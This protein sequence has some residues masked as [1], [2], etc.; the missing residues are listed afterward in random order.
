[1][2][3][4]K[5]R[6]IN[7]TLDQ[8]QGALL[9]FDQKVQ[10]KNL[11]KHEVIEKYFE[12]QARLA[13][14]SQGEP[15]TAYSQEDSKRLP[16]GVYRF[17]TGKQ[18]IVPFAGIKRNDAVLDLGCGIGAE[19][20]FAAEASGPLG[21]VLGIDV[22]GYLIDRAKVWA[23]DKGFRHVRFVHGPA[24]E[25]PLSDRIIDVAILNHSF[26]LM[27]HEPV[28][29]ELA[30]VMKR[31]GR[32]IIAGVFKQPGVPPKKGAFEQP[33]NWIH[34]AA[35]AKSF[36]EYCETAMKYGFHSSRFVRSSGVDSSAGCMI[37]ERMPTLA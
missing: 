7:L 13:A 2:C 34:F 26:H 27:D 24:E 12:L 29:K 5:S 11:G 18:H 33:S 19:A 14:F 23:T 8:V 10:E 1:M 4:E 31:M 21:R 6:E 37:I 35:G 3:P 17:T 15:N 28:I 22:C 30:R 20:Y 9:S 32:I 36:D 16:V 25:L